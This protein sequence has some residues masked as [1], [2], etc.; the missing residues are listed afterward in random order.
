MRDIKS[1]D[2]F[3]YKKC[4]TNINNK[5]RVSNSAKKRA[6][7]QK[8]PER[9]KVFLYQKYHTKKTKDVRH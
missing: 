4:A 5:S 3:G 7:A 6:Y 8:I 9:M 1:V 2:R